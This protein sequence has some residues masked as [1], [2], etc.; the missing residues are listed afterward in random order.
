MWGENSVFSWLKI[1]P[2]EHR[3]LHKPPGGGFSGSGVIG[4][5]AVAPATGLARTGTWERHLCSIPQLLASSSLGW[6]GRQQHAWGPTPPPYMHVSAA[7]LYEYS[8]RELMWVWS[9]W[10][11]ENGLQLRAMEY[12]S[13]IFCPHYFKQQKKKRL[14]FG[15]KYFGGVLAFRF[16]HIYWEFHG[17][18]SG[19]FELNSVM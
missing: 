12:F 7:A 13:Q 11:E 3:R 4:P 14:R 17:S 6:G 9:V 1:M 15:Q 10:E 19:V 5:A 8:L 18:C 2:A 16:F